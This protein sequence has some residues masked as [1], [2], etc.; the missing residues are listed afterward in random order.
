LQVLYCFSF[1]AWQFWIIHLENK[2]AKVRE[3]EDR[4]AGFDQPTAAWKKSEAREGLPRCSFCISAGLDEQAIG[5][6][7]TDSNG[8]VTCPVLIER[9]K[10]RSKRKSLAIYSSADA[11]NALPSAS[12]DDAPD[13]NQ[14][15]K[16]ASLDYV[17]T[18]LGGLPADAVPDIYDPYLK[19]N[20]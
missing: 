8:I 20:T 16:D 13:D 19:D 7:V 10:A 15:R 14:T 6:S 4:L 11:D 2:A 3:L 9:N 12:E 17:E 1:L 5:H 18:F